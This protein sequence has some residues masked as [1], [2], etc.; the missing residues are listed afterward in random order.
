MVLSV[1]PTVETTTNRMEIEDTTCKTYI[2][3]IFTQKGICN[4]NEKLHL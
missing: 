2:N 4:L 1:M 3:H